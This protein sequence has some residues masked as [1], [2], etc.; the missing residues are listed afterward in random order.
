M[1]NANFI[2]S[3]DHEASQLANSQADRAIFELDYSLWGILRNLSHQS[4]PL[5]AKLFN[6]KDSTVETAAALS[7]ECLKYLSSGV[8]L[9]F[10]LAADLKGIT[11]RLKSEVYE[12]SFEITDS[13]NFVDLYWIQLGVIARKDPRMACQAFGLPM[14][15]V[16]VAAEA[17]M[18]QLAKLSKYND[19]NY[20]LR[21][22]EELIADLHFG[23]KVRN[24]QHV[25]MMKLQQSI[26]L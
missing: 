19:I 18:I 26:C 11:A 25:L 17:T 13:S 6:L 20:R 2:D 1:L 23:H 24:I 5:A 7:D 12:Q 22:R 3:L 15:L 4:A 14:E 10:Q 16:L 21:F 8:I 9:S